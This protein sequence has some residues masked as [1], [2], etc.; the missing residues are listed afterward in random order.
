MAGM[1]TECL[2]VLTVAA[3]DICFFP[4]H[5][6]ITSGRV[7]LSGQYSAWAQHTTQLLT[8]TNHK[9]RTGASSRYLITLITK[10][11]PEEVQ[12]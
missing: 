9:D 7:L 11:L 5:I 3:A 2:V 6:T 12:L 8:N 4:L 10:P 1:H